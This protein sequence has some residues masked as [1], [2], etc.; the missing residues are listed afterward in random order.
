MGATWDVHERLD[1]DEAAAVE[2]LL[3]SIEAD[4]GEEALSEPAPGWLAR[5]ERRHALRREGAALTGYAALAVDDDVDAEPAFGT[6]DLGLVEL[7]EGLGRPTSLLVR[8]QSEE[9]EPLI[10]RGWVLV[11]HLHRLRRPLPAEP[12]P[13]L[14]SGIA[15][16][17]FVPGAD[18]ARWVEQN[19]DAFGDDRVQG[20]MTVALLEAKERAAWFDPEGFLLFE[21]GDSLVASCWTKVHRTGAVDVG[22]IY[23][24]SVAPTAQGRGLGRLAVLEGLRYLA[25]AGLG[26]AELYVRADNVAANGLYASLGFRRDLEVAELRYQPE[27]GAKA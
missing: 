17:S 13:P 26:L 21:E 15:R 1:A 24:V 9:F 27:T 23:V 20:S 12:P 6:W 22:E 4:L 5:G 7:L 11:R 3:T 18:E 25:D 16:R 2:G 14:P 10:E 8:G 19:N